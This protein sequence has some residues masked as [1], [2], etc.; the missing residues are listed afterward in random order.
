MRRPMRN[1]RPDVYSNRIENRNICRNF[2]LGLCRRGPNCKY[3]HIRNNNYNT[4]NNELSTRGFSQYPPNRFDYRFNEVESER[5]EL[6]RIVRERMRERSPSLL[7]RREESARLAMHQFEMLESDRLRLCREYQTGTCYRGSS[8]RYRHILR[9]DLDDNGCFYQPA[10]NDTRPPPQPVCGL[11]NYNW[12]SRHIIS[13]EQISRYKIDRTGV[14]RSSFYHN[15]IDNNAHIDTPQPLI[16]SSSEADP[17]VD[18][19]VV[20]NLSGKSR[21]RST[22]FGAASAA[23]ESNMI[24][25]MYYSTTKCKDYAQGTC[26]FDVFCKYVHDPPS[27]QGQTPSTIFSP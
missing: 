19:E 3:L 10:I 17:G 15:N 23:D 12:R 26:N 5:E 18:D 20:Q 16:P 2:Q 1:P 14:N 22:M 27:N 9:Q 7:L 11:K 21:P 13:P 8:C 4:C 6:C 24:M 25:K